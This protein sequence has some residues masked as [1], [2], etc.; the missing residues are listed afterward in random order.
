MYQPNS[1]EKIRTAQKRVAYTWRGG[2]TPDTPVVRSVRC[3]VRRLV[4]SGKSS[5]RRPGI[6]DQPGGWEGSPNLP[7]STAA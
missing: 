3:L 4:S 6:S 2:P 7:S 5:L 1:M